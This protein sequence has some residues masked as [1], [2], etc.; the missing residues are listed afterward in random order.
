MLIIQGLV[1]LQFRNELGLSEDWMHDPWHME[2][3]VLLSISLPVWMYFSFFD[4]TKRGTPGKRIMSLK[5][6]TGDD[7]NLGFTL[8]FIRTIFKLLPWELAH[9]GVIFPRPLYFNTQDDIR[10][11]T[12]AGIGLLI[13]YVISLII[14]KDRRTLY[15]HLT[16]S[17]VTF[18]KQM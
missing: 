10:F 15:D 18:G 12:Y 9:I 1:L 8:A 3:Y 5:I 11:A 13:V 7:R 16:G 4:Q 6:S 14:S 2:V 17:R